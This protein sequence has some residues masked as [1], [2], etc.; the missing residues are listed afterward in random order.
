MVCSKPF[1]SPILYPEEEAYSLTLIGAEFDPTAVFR[2][3]YAGPCA[4]A[5]LPF[6]PA[7]VRCF[8]R[9]VEAKFALSFAALLTNSSAQIRQAVLWR[10]VAT[11]VTVKSG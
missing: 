1:R 8:C 6:T 5:Y 11:W 2:H 3:L 7:R 9:N 4:A 10:E